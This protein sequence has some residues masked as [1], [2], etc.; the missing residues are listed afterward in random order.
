MH[1]EKALRE[2]EK[3]EG[4]YTHPTLK[5]NQ[6]QAK[7]DDTQ[8]VL[9]AAKDR[10]KLAVKMAFDTAEKDHRDWMVKVKKDMAKKLLS[11]SPLLIVI[12]RLKT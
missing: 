2:K 8:K 1:R 9:D 10:R 4:E 6:M 11:R 12:D 5:L 3:A 7:L